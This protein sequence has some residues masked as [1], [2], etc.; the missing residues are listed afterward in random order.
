MNKFKFLTIGL[1]SLLALFSCKKDEKNLGAVISEHENEIKAGIID[2][3]EIK[4]YSHLKDSVITS[5]KNDQTFGIINSNEFGLA[6][7]SLYASLIPDSLN[8]VF[9][10]SNYEINSFYIQLHITDFYGKNIDQDFEVLKIKEAVNPESTYYNFDSISVGEKLGSFTINLSDSGIYKF[11]LDSAAGQYLFSEVNSNYE[12]KEAFKNFFGGIYITP[13]TPPGLNEGAIYK[14][15]KTGIS[16]HLSYS[17]TNEM[18]NEYDTDIVYTIENETNIFSNLDHNFDGSETNT[19]FND[20]TLGQ[21]AFFAQGLSG[22]YG[23]IEF[24]TLQKWFNNE[25]FNYLITGYKF[26]VFAEQNS[27]FDLPV[28]LIL[29]YTNSLGLRS[30]K[31]TKLNLEEN[32]YTFEIYNAEVNTALEDGVFDKMDFQISLPLPESSPEQVKLLGLN[33][34]RPPQLIITYAKY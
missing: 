6:K 10:K 18:D 29:T 22:A 26:R 33:S 4:T 1:C 14:L 12:S 25:S 30:Y 16:L 3:F 28:Q 32:S 9:P 13:T 20:S 24:P 15:N 34:E 17:T 31:S 11:N 7:S 2:S 8:I 21:K 27:I 5:G 23:K 19:V